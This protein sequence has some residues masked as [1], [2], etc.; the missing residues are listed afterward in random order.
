MQKEK[1]IEIF[2]SS[3]KK[4]RLNEEKLQ[5]MEEEKT[6]AM[7]MAEKTHQER[8]AQACSTSRSLNTQILNCTS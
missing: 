4:I 6:D 3:D 5:T 2:I 8:E 1:K 7:E